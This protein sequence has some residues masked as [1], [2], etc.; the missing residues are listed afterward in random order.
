MQSF[1]LSRFD[2]LQWKAP[3]C[4]Q[5]A[6]Q[7]ILVPRSPRKRDGCDYVVYVVTIG[8][9]IATLCYC[10]DHLFG[11][12]IRANLKTNLG[13]NTFKILGDAYEP[14]LRGAAALLFFWLLLYWM[15]RKKM[16]LRI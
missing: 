5:A 11:G 16:L 3:S 4:R 12:F 9:G 2:H 8:G 15:Y 7:F 13:Q 14:F 10:M 1:A 6:H